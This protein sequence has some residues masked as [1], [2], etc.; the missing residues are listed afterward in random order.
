MGMIFAASVLA[1]LASVGSGLYLPGV[2]PNNYKAGDKVELKVNSLDSVKTQLPYEYYKMPFCPPEGKIVHS[3]ENLGEYLIGDRIENS[4]YELKMQ[5]NENCKILCRTSVNAESE[6]SFMNLIENEYRVN[7]LA[8]NLPVFT[9]GYGILRGKEVERYDVGFPVG[10]VGSHDQGT[11]G[12]LYIFNHIT[13]NFH[14]YTVDKSDD[15]IFRIVGFEVSPKSV[16]HHAESWDE[17]DPKKLKLSTCPHEADYSPL[18]LKDATNNGIV[19]TYDV[20]WI[21]SDIPWAYRWD[22]Y[23]QMADSQI[24]WFS[25]VNS[26]MIIVFLTGMVAMILLRTLRRDFA[27]YNK[28]DLAEDPD[29]DETGWKFVHA[30]VFRTPKYPGLLATLTA[31]GAQVFSMSLITIFFAA[32]GF[33]SPANRGALM[34]GALLIYV[35][36]GFIAGYVGTR[37]Y[38]MFGLLNWRKNTLFTALVFPGFNFGI[39]FILNLII[40]GEGSSAAIPFFEIFALLVLWFGISVPLVFLGS[41][42]ANQRPPVTHPVRVNQIP[43]QIPPQPWFMKSFV[44]IMIGGILPFG[45]VFIEV[46]FIMTSI[47][48]HRFYYVFGFL[49]IVFVIL[50]ITCAEI[51]IVMCYFQLCSED[52]KWWWRSY[53][54]SGAAAI[55]L[56]LYSILY[57]ATKLDITDFVPGLLYFGYT[58]LICSLFFVLT[59]TIGFL[60]TLLFV[61]K[62]YAAIR[63]D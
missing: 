2:A 7:M 40:W 8:D 30:D 15:Q 11:P 50:I 34:S 39:F 55:Y 1:V 20:N 13:L 19:W 17:S 23:L 32:L 53:L 35:F 51:T 27:R 3:P 46:F 33:L 63:I 56:F 4:F 42:V 59:G 43:R 58:S 45:A 6:G 41:Y 44:S 26:I 12:E 37:I 47:W 21:P 57:F 10:V 16:K 60:S 36:M 28:E 5:E 18:T 54:T 48:F 49:L 61:R 31:T 24:H 14:V 62:I 9:K 25:I 52:Y 22:V 38:T 29:L